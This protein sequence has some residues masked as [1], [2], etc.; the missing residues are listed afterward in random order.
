[1]ETQLDLQLE[2]VAKVGIN[3]VTCGNCGT[4]VLHRIEDEVIICPDCGFESDPC[5]FPDLNY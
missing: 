3:I 5:D 2:I 1:M 4:V